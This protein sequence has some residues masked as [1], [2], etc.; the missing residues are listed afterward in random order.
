[1]LS[2]REGASICELTEVLKL[3]TNHIQHHICKYGICRS[4]NA[5]ET[6]L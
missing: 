3:Y 6:S 1:M 4:I 5:L 2:T